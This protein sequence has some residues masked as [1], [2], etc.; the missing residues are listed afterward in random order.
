MQLSFDLFNDQLAIVNLSNHLHLEPWELTLT[1][2]L[3][4]SEWKAYPYPNSTIGSKSYYILERPNGEKTRIWLGKYKNAEQAKKSFHEQ[5]IFNQLLW[6][7][8]I[9]DRILAEYPDSLHVKRKITS[10]MDRVNIS[11]S[12]YV[13]VGLTKAAMP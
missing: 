3:S 7:A 4:M 2:F 9:D 5:Q 10:Y 12:G 6:G 1:E 13:H 8:D 11:S